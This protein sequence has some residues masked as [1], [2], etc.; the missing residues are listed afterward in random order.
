M[1]TSAMK[2]ARDV[3]AYEDDHPRLDMNTKNAADR[4]SEAIQAAKQACSCKYDVIRHRPINFNLDFSKQRLALENLDILEPPSLPRICD[5]LCTQSHDKVTLQ[6]RSSNPEDVDCYELQYA[7]D[8]QSP[9][10]IKPDN[11]MIV[12][13]IRDRHYTL[14]GMQTGTRYVFAVRAINQAGS[15]LSDVITIKTLGLYGAYDVIKLF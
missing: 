3:C 14:H 7:I 12:P 8:N 4:L 6:W 5:E 13:N 15:N 10:R 11:W 9:S 2:S 1:M